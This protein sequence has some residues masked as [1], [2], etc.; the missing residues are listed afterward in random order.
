MIIAVVD[1]GAHKAHNARDVPP[2]KVR[3]I[4]NKSVSMK[5]LVVWSLSSTNFIEI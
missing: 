2:E 4:K 1:V 3:F 5:K